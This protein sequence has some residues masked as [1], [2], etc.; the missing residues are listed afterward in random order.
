MNQYTIYI[1]LALCA[2]ILAIFTAIFSWRMRCNTGVTYLTWCM[3]FIT[4]FLITNM[5]ELFDPTESGTL[6][7]AK[8]SYLFNTLIPVG[9]I[10]F[11]LEFTG[12]SQWAIPRRGWIFFIIPL[13]SNV[14]IQIDALRSWIWQVYTFVA[15]DHLF[16]LR[17][18][19][20]GWW[21]W[22]LLI[23]SYFLIFLGA[24]LIVLHTCHMHSVYRQQSYWLVLGAV[25]PIIVN[26]IYNFRL[27]PQM[28]KDFSPISYAFSG[29]FILLGVY[30]SHLLD[31]V[32]VARGALVDRMS[33]GLVVLDRLNRIVD[34]N[35]SAQ[36][37]ASKTEGPIIGS[38]IDQAFP[39]WKDLLLPE[40]EEETVA[41][42][43]IQHSKQEFQYEVRIII[44]RDSRAR[45]I[46][47][48]LMLHDITSYKMLLADVIN[49]AQVDPLTGINN[50]RHFFDLATL[51]LERARRYRLP[52]SIILVDMDH[53]KVINDTYGHI[54]GDRVLIEVTRCLKTGLRAVDTIARYGGDEFVIL[55]PETGPSGALQL[56]E[57][58]R[59]DIETMR[60]EELPADISHTISI[61]IVSILG[62]EKIKF[63]Q[64]LDCADSAMYK[65]KTEGG[66]RTTLVN[67]EKDLTNQD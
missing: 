67:W 44:L 34:I 20:Y 40:D 7:W 2:T 13:L 41:E 51:E 60:A 27:L 18:L 55:L 45:L 52:L 26:V 61:G 4:G 62:G 29:L 10:L 25:L 21:F 3:V 47:T 50:R 36:T 43:S 8:S 56:I 14:I 58:L 11:I 66:N 19:E 30:N 65:S 9:W 37:I 17:A 33:D 15:V 12:R 24:V 1:V 28:T 53:L 31:L 59:L 42:V 49:L 57:R 64:L 22:V 5:L 46:G 32:P 39:F 6:F 16:V 54:A 38:M 63:D 23:Y 48:L 35:P